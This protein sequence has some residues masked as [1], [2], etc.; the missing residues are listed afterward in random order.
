[1]WRLTPLKDVKLVD[2][3]SIAFRK[4]KLRSNSLDRIA[5]YARILE[6]KTPVLMSTWMDAML[7]GN[8]RAMDYIVKHCEADIKVLGA[9]LDVVKPFVKAFDDRGSAL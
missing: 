1:H 8:K 7:N 2:P 5:D 6:R 9:V 3:C 4:F